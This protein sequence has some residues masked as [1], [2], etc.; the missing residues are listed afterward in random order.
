[1]SEVT[2]AT[3]VDRLMDYV[4]GVLPADVRAGI[5]QH[6]AQCPRCVAYIA[7]YRETPRILRQA[8]AAAMA[9]EQR[10]SLQAFLRTLRS[11]S[12]HNK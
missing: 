8:T 1:M 11:D 9:A 12:Q 2:C 10:Q 3:G 5:E 4:E 6:V 7:S